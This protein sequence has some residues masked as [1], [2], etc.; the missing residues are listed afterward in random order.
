LALDVRRAPDRGPPVEDRSEIHRVGR[1]RPE[2]DRAADCA[3]CS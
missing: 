3:T 2:Q 1:A